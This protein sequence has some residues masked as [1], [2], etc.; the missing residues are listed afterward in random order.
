ME[1]C[2]KCKSDKVF[3][4]NAL[5]ISDAQLA[6]AIDENPDAAIFKNRTTSA[7]IVKTCGECG[8]LEFYAENP[9]WLYQAYLLAERQKNETE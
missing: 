2:V 4:A 9:N 5:T 8:Y 7:T 6:I 1:K 3:P